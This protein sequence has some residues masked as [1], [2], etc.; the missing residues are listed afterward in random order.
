MNS[1]S[2]TIQY[3]AAGGAPTANPFSNQGGYG[4][5]FDPGTNS[6]FTVSPPGLYRIDLANGNPSTNSSLVSSVF[7]GT[8][9]LTV[10]VVPE[11]GSLVLLS[12]GAGL[13]VW[14]MRRAGTFSGRVP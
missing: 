14:R 7:N 11:P 10:H 3:P 13:L 2:P 8:E 6:L 1:N 9:Y 12:L 4:I 5:V